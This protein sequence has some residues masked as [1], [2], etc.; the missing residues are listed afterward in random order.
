MKIVKM[1]PKIHGPSLKKA[2]WN[3]MIKLI[4]LSK[5]AGISPGYLSELENEKKYCFHLK[6]IKKLQE[7]LK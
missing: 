5:T 1:V 4:D 7:A 2:R 3:K 6:T